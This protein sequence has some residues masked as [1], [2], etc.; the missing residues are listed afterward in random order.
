MVFSERNTMMARS[1][2]KA[3]FDPAQE[4]CL[5]DNQFGISCG[6]GNSLCGD[7]RFGAADRGSPRDS[8]QRRH[9]RLSAGTLRART[10]QV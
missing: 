5:D 4:F 9:G 6:Y 7:V 1:R 2:G 8:R 10:F 3:R